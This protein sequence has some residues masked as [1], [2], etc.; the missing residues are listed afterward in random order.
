M[1]LADFFQDWIELLI[2]E[3]YGFTDQEQPAFFAGLAPAEASLVE[4]IL[5]T[6]WDEL[7]KL[8]LD[9]QSENALTMLGMLCTQQRM[10]DRF[11]DLARA[12]GTRAWQRIT[13]MS[14]MAEKCKRYD[15]A[16]GVYEACMG[17]GMHQEFLQ[18]KY[19]EL[20]GRLQK[21]KPK[22]SKA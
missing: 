11:L 3:D 12:M 2:W 7:S 13:T 17:P 9:Y 18:K 22:R 16:V 4:A 5:R 10:F 1:P 20:Q 21:E 14:E 15:L 6:Q 8:D 19:A